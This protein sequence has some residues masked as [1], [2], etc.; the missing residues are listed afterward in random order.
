MRFI[1]T[2]Y[3]TK[4]Q[5]KHRFNHHQWLKDELSRNFYRDLIYATIAIKRSLNPYPRRL[6]KTVET[7]NK[8]GIRV[9]RREHNVHGLIREKQKFLISFF[10]VSEMVGEKTAGKERKN[11]G[12]GNHFYVKIAV[13]FT[14]KFN[15]IVQQRKILIV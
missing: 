12:E 8:S 14:L 10:I 6:G 3:Q 5:R 7:G 1:D 13:E 4:Q 15:P 2:K 11:G 9:L